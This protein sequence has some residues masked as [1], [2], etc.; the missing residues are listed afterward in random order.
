MSSSFVSFYVIMIYH[1]TIFLFLSLS[2][3]APEV[4]L[5][6]HCN[7][8]SDMFSLGLIICSLFNHGKSLLQSNNNPMLYLRQ[9]EYVSINLCFTIWSCELC[10]T[11]A[12]WV[13]FKSFF[14]CI[15]RYTGVLIWKVTFAME[16][17]IPLISYFFNNLLYPSNFLTDSKKREG[18]SSVRG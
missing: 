2:S 14:I 10:T 7:I 12:R 16:C 1:V 11:F 9:I 8:L 3:T 17:F 18:F 6:G 15:D 4:Q 13:T 5:S